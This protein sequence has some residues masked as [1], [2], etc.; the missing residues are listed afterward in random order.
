MLLAQKP[1]QRGSGPDILKA[2]KQRF[3]LQH[4]CKYHLMGLQT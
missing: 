1:S 4:L 2:A 3:E